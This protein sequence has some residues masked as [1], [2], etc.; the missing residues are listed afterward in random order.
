MATETGTV[1]MIE[2]VAVADMRTTG[3]EEAVEAA[4]ADIDVIYCMLYFG[5]NSTLLIF[6]QRC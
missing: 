5:L 6:K 3:R 2:D 1:T 4:D